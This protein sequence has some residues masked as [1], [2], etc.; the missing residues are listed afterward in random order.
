MVSVGVD[1]VKL[2]RFA[3]IQTPGGETFYHRVY[4]RA[5]QAAYGKASQRLAACFSGK[6]AVSK[7]LGT[8]L[9]IGETAR[10]ACHD[11]EVLCRPITGQPEL[12]LTDRALSIAAELGLTQI[13]LRWFHTTE[14]V[15][16]VAGGIDAI[17]A[18]ADLIG[19]IEDT[20][21]SIMG[22]IA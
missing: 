5:E 11:I 22:R 8:G 19:I 15:V 9:M 3:F 20:G 21:H 10:V 16:S 18:L 12:Q 14:F 6:E 1:L 2:D 17:D 4:T 13:A 7:V